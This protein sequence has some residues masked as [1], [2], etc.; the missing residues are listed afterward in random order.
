MWWGP[1]RG[2]SFLDLSSAQ[3]KKILRTSPLIHFSR[4]ADD[5]CCNEK[6][7]ISDFSYRRYEKNF[8]Y[9]RYEKN[10]I[11][12]SGAHRR[13]GARRRRLRRLPSSRC[14]FSG[15][16]GGKGRPHDFGGRRSRLSRGAEAHQTIVANARSR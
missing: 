13:A 8:S 14:A 3:P 11:F 10:L 12:G 16:G 9:R 5:S 7:L 4:S 6:F 1:S 15:W 2:S